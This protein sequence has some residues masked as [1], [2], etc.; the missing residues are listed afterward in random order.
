M[1]N[2]DYREDLAEIRIMM[3]RSTR[4][5]SVPGWAG[6]LAG[7]Y[8]ITAAWIAH[9]C[10][11]LKILFAQSPLIQ[12]AH[13]KQTIGLGILL[14]LTSMTTA[15]TLSIRQAKGKG[16]PLWNQTT[17]RMLVS[18]SIPLL[19][20]G[21]VLVFLMVQGLLDWVF[22]FSLI[23]Y[24]L[25]LHNAGRE[26]IPELQFLGYLELGLG[27]VACFMSSCS[28]LLWLMGF[29]GLHLL[30]GWYITQKYPS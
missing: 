14:L 11:G 2:T 25:A 23:F 28:V 1:K 10:F 30:Y 3:D 17:R 18:F 20:G 19:T 12:P 4:F 5:R 29:G 7:L 6:I 26:S 27:L 8:A 22:P 21:V 15:I 9:E 16:T 24:G 13:A